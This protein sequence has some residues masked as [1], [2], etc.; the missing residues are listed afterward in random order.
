M[1][2]KIVQLIHDITQKDYKVSFAGDFQCMVR[3]EFTHEYDSEFYDHEHLN[4]PDG[5]MEKLEE[6]IQEAL[7]EFLEKISND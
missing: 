4:Y 1:K 5:P 7:V 2:N 3:I 6:K